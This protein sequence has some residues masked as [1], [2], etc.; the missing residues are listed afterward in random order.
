MAFRQCIQEES[1]GGV[2]MRVHRYV[3]K[4][5]VAR[6]LPTGVEGQLHY[7]AE[8]TEVHQLEI[9]LNNGAVLIQPGALQYSYGNLTVDVIRHEANKGFFARAADRISNWWETARWWVRLLIMVLVGLVIALVVLLIRKLR[10]ARRL[11]HGSP[12]G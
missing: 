4:K 5:M 6:G 1:R 12:F 10:A 3:E 7:I 9:E 8:P 11:P 2:T